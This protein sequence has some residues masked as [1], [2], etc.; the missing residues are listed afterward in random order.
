VAGLD[1]DAEDM[2]QGDDYAPPHGGV[3]GYSPAYWCAQRLPPSIRVVGP[4]ELL[5]RL[6]MRHDPKQTQELVRQFQP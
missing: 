5:W 3:R 2:P 4:E 1:E 6:R